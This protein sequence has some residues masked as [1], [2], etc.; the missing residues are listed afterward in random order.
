[1]ST[2]LDSHTYLPAEDAALAPMADLLAEARSGDVALV[3]P[4][5]RVVIDAQIY[6]ILEQVISA[7]QAG[8][9]VTITPESQ[10]LTTQ[11][12]ADLLGISRPTFV[13]FLETGEIPYERTT[14]RRAVAIEDVLAFRR[15]RKERQLEA[16][17]AIAADLDDEPTT[18]DRDELL[19]QARAAA[20]ER[21]RRRRQ[22]DA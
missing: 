18:A 10:R 22:K 8:K 20:A 4:T 17:A 12:A 5:G 19:R 1:M 2:A 3:G 15:A 14:H 6:Q 7:M 13:K 9:A 11:Q 16:L 21:R